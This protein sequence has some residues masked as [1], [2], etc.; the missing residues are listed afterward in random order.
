[1][2]SQDPHRINTSVPHPARRY[3][4][5]LGGKDNFQA[6]RDSGDAIAEMFPSVR[7][8]V[9]ANRAFMRRAVTYV[10]GQGVSQFLDIGTGIPAPNNTHEVAQ[11][12]IPTARVV[13]VD[14]D[15]IVLSHA[16][17]LMTSGEG[18]QTAYIEADLRDYEVI[19][20]HPDLQ[21]VLD[22]DQPTA[23]L[24][25]AILHFIVDADDPAGIVAGLVRRLAPGSYLVMSHG[26][27]DFAPLEQR[28]PAAKHGSLRPR[29]RAEVAELVAGLEL[30]EPGIVPISGWRNDD[31]G[32]HLTPRE[33]GIYGLVARVP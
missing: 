19:L 7:A 31:E 6:D 24:L 25:V 32:P 11:A 13:Y 27:A 2:T 33:D 12:L 4:Y 23:V 15:P 9:L 26:T 10:A 18:G 3:N 29:D 30:V 14:N 28:M 20:D 17:A 5:W 21:R 1:L 22:L 16:R 8:A